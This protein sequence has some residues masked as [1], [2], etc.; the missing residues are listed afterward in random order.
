MG[1]T[2]VSAIFHSTPCFTASNDAFEGHLYLEVDGSTL[3]HDDVV[4]WC[5]GQR[6]YLNSRDQFPERIY[7]WN[8]NRSDNNLSFKRGEENRSFLGHSWKLP[9]VERNSGKEMDVRR[10]KE[11]LFELLISSFYLEIDGRIFAHKKKYFSSDLF[12][13]EDNFSHIFDQF[14]ME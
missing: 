8:D 11:R 4:G 2:P 3:D 9:L 14:L 13:I 10:F 12:W 1:T 6:R 7:S 5:A